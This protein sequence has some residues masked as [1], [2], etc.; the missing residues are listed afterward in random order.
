MNSNQTQKVNQFV[1]FTDLDDT[2]LD[3]T[4]RYDYA[5]PTL[6]ILK[7]RN[8]PVIL[9]SNKTY[10]EQIKYIKKLGISHPFIVEGGSGIYIPKG[11]FKK[12]QGKTAGNFEVVV[13]GIEFNKIKKALD[14]IKDKYHYMSYYT[15]TIEEVAERMELDIEGAKLAKNRQFTETVLEADAGAIKELQQNFNLVFGGRAFQISGKNAGKGKAV[16]I[17]K[18]LY[19]EKIG[20]FTSIGLGNSYNDEPMLKEVD[21]PILI[22]NPDGNW[23]DIH[24]DKLNKI[25]EIGPKGWS[26]AIHQ[27]VLN[28]QKGC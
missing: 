8:I 10:A 18:K 14:L 4:Y 16:N 15:M 24:I 1:I 19:A 7:E 26:K 17:L 12:Q 9:C 25:D 20:D 2:L 13:L 5:K 28:L 22:K 21:I 6:N 3:N 27:F 23:A 11:Y